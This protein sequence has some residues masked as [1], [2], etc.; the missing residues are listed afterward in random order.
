MYVFV[1]WLSLQKQWAKFGLRV[2]VCHRS[3]PYESED[4]YLGSNPNST[5]YLLEVGHLCV[6]H[7]YLIYNMCV[8]I[9]PA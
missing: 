1:F 7:L 4:K 9:A 6:S 2:I 8:R 3:W 5:I